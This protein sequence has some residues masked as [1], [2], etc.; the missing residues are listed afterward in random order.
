MPSD[1]TKI[2]EECFIAYEKLKTG[3]AAFIL[4]EIKDEVIVVNQIGKPAD[5]YNDY[6]DAFLEALPANECRYGVL[7]LDDVMDHQGI[8][9]RELVFY[10]WAPDQC[11]VKQRMMHSTSLIIFRRRLVGPGVGIEIQAN[12]VSEA[13][14][15]AVFEKAQRR[16]VF[17]Q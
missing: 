8:K 13:Q 7:Y 3:D 12:D 10:G 14:R 1:G 4:F 15:E 9:K 17:I 11:H 6:Y 2:A 5:A 16:P